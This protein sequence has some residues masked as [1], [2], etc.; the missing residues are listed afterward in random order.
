M[1]DGDK[2]LRG[3]QVPGW[4]SWQGS[5]GDARA[6][7][8]QGGFQK[9]LASLDK[10]GGCRQGQTQLRAAAGQTLAASSSWEA[11]GCVDWHSRAQV[12]ARAK[13]GDDAALPQR[14]PGGSGIGWEGSRAGI[15]QPKL[16]HLF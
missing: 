11:S 3:A 6:A 15:S 4:A 12:P 7:S 14:R 16:L 5:E 8:R 2:E 10:E 13:E 1:G 9:A